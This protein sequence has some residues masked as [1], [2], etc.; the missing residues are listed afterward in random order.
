MS[1]HFSFKDTLSQP[2]HGGARESAVQPALRVEGLSFAYENGRQIFHD[3]SFRLYP[4]EILQILGANGCGKS[5]LMNCLARQ[6]KPQQ[7]RV[8]LQGDELESLPRE[9]LARR[10]AYVPQLQNN[11]CSFLVRD[12]ITMGRAPY[13]KLLS[14]PGAEDYELADQVME[15]LHITHLAEKRLQQISGGERQQAQIARALV[16]QSRIILFDEPT[17]H[18]D[19]GNQHRIIMLISAL[20]AQGYAVITTTHIPDSP[21]LTGGKVGMFCDG[22][23]HFGE[24]EELVTSEALRRIYHI[25]VDVLYIE[26]LGRKACFCHS[27]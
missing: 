18:L 24:A 1:K 6:L 13:L 10:L 12:Y 15:Q 22:G 21:L 20:A 14:M 4:G 11:S 16:Q 26:A 23:F 5:T 7:G 17:N 25:N 27:A 3:V 2:R 19:Y 8:L 9:E